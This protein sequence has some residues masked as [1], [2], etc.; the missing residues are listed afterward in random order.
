MMKRITV[1][2]IAISCSLFFS[3]NI[4]SANA[5]TPVVQTTTQQ[6]VKLTEEQRQLLHQKK[7]ELK[8]KYFQNWQGMTTEEK[9]IAM[10][11][12]K[13][14]LQQYCKDKLGIACDGIPK[15]DHHHNFKRFLP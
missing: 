14:E 8:A 4:V 10:M 5:L 7:E 12:Y 3:Q 1:S 11:D 15:R 13:T 9:K 6:K 2:F